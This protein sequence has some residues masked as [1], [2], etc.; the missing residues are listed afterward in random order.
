MIAIWFGLRTGF[1]TQR[2]DVSSSGNICH[3]VRFAA[4]ALL[5]DPE[6]RRR[7]SVTFTTAKPEYECSPGE[8]LWIAEV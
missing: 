5:P 1:C 2:L 6:Q 3:R 4:D 7:E 8:I